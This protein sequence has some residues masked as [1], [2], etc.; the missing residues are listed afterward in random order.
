MGW[1]DFL[2]YGIYRLVRAGASA[3]RR[4]LAAKP[5]CH[6]VIGSCQACEIE[7]RQRL[8]NE[9]A[10]SPESVELAKQN[11][12]KEIHEAYTAIDEETRARLRTAVEERIQ[13]LHLRTRPGDVEA[14]VVN[15]HRRFKRNQS[16]E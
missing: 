14:A 16:L 11:R 1:H 4:A 6:G 13:R 5:C 8:E 3:G 7:R 12:W 10:R 15:M 2:V 9:F